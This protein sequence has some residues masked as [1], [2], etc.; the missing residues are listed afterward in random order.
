MEIM[1][2]SIQSA[3]IFAFPEFPWQ[4]WKFKEKLPLNWWNNPQ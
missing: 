1:I 3:L 2:G 4:A